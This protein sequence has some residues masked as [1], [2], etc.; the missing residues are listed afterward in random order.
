[1]TAAKPLHG[2]VVIELCQNVAGPYAGLVLAQLGA[3]VIKIERT[4]VGDD[5]RRWGPPFVRDD[6]LM[7]HVMNA[8][9]ESVE[10]DLKQDTDR[11]K[12]LQLLRGA[13]VFI[14]SLR[15]GAMER[16]GLGRDVVRGCNDQLIYCNISAFGSRGPLANEPGY[17]PLIQAFTGM[18]STTGEDG[19]PPVRVGTSVIDMSTGVWVVIS[20]LAALR[21][22]ADTGTGSVVDTSLFEVGLAWMPYQLVGRMMTEEEPKRLGSGLGMLVP[23]QAFEAADR[24]I[25][26]A[27]GNDD[28]WKRLCDAL[29]RPDLATD[30]DLVTNAGRVAARERVAEEVGLTIRT[31]AA[32]DWVARLHEARVAVSLVQGLGEVLAHPQTSAMGMIRPADDSPGGSMGLPFTLDGVRAFPSIGAPQLGGSG[33]LRM[34]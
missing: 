16:A 34:A 21:Q 15:P 28:A 29:E 4:S 27:V 3:R 5:T 2:I 31:R 30:P 10:L 33:E 11:A 9:K 32:S 22:R 26:V 13:D 23:Y 8:G 14:Q 1:M 20:V 24:F 12:L 18:M 19:R 7:F 25:I 17:D 6:G